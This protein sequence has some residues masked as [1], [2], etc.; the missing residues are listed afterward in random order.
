MTLIVS[1]LKCHEAS[2]ISSS[3]HEAHQHYCQTNSTE[4]RKYP[5]TRNGLICEDCGREGNEAKKD[6]RTEDAGSYP[7]QKFAFSH[8]GEA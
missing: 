4:H 1:P 3:L 7:L 5:E 6:S 2:S 8:E